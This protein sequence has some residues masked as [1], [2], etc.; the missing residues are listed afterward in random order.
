[1]SINA[2]AWNE[3]LNLRSD[4]RAV[5]YSFQN[6][7]LKFNSVSSGKNGLNTLTKPLTL[8]SMTRRIVNFN[9]LLFKCIPLPIQSG[10]NNAK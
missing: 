8:H 3:A 6:P 5:D 1:M 4:Y 10:H 9:L 2:F 7:I